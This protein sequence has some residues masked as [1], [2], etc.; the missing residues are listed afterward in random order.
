MKRRFFYW[1]LFITI[2]FT[3]LSGV[4]AVYA[5]NNPY[6]DMIQK[7]RGQ[8]NAQ[9]WGQLETWADYMHDGMYQEYYDLW[10]NN[11]GVLGYG[12]DNIVTE[13]LLNEGYYT[14]YV[15]HLKEAG[16]I[17]PDYQ[18]PTNKQQKATNVS[19]ED[20]KEVSKTLPAITTEKCEEKVMW[21]KSQVNVR[22]NGSIDYKKVGSLQA[23]EQV[24]V[25]GIDSTG[26]YEIRKSDGTVG[27]VSDKYLTEEDP[28]VKATPEEE[29]EDVVTKRESEIISID[30]R[31]VIWYN[32]E[33]EEEEEVVF[34][35]N[36]PLEEV[37]DMAMKYLINGAELVEQPSEET[38][39]P[40]E[41][42]E[43][44]EV[45]EEPA[46]VKTEPIVE[47][48]T[49]T[50]VVEEPVQAEDVDEAEL[51]EQTDENQGGIQTQI[52]VLV[53]ALLGLIIIAGIVIMIR[54]RKRH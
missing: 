14:E 50:P 28:S 38:T 34:S 54:T 31:T 19:E 46:S 36:T 49:N 21:A 43:T 30:G 51:Q 42:A 5:S 40:E 6:Y 11:P 17:R 16:I 45:S 41:V 22:E 1:L 26:W 35:D 9:K 13:I 29:T 37:E 7:Y 24:T 47:E 44:E 18:L 15:D 3:T 12:A 10:I 32:A 48:T 53:S 2:V 25:T 52:I 4:K 27:H 8:L 33:T 23:G 39:P 20:K